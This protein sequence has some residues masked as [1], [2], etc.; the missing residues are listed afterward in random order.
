[1]SSTGEKIKKLRTSIG[2][3]QEQLAEELEISLKSVHRYESGKSRP[4][5]HTIIK[6]ATFFDVSSDYLLGLIGIKNQ[7]KVEKNKVSKQGQYNQF[8]KRY[9]NCKNSADID[10]SAIYYWI[11]FGDKNDFGGQS[12][13]VGWADEERTLEVRRLRPVIPQAAIK[14]CTSVYERPMLINSKADALIFRIFGGHAIVKA[15][16]C[17]K[18]LPE[19]YED[20][21]GPSPER[22]VLKSI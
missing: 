20:Y 9:L 16:I 2:L 17:K 4:D 15:D 13:W 22:D 14:L 3:S 5:T 8:Y 1:M 12:E 10:E 11:Y 18:Y 19:F 21:V 7:M 6:L